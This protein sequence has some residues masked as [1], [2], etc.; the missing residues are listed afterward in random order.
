VTILVILV[1]LTL[2]AVPCVQGAEPYAGQVISVVDFRGKT[3]TLQKP[4]RRIVCL[5]E[6]ALSGFFMLDAHDRVVGIS[7]NVYQGE[8]YPYYAGM[9]RR[10]A[11]KSLPAPGNWDFVNLERVV[12]LD[13]DLVVIWAHQEESIRA[14]EERGI[15][16]FGVFI[17]SFED[18]Y[19]E[20]RAL[21]ELTG[22]PDRA[23]AL[24]RYTQTEILNLQKMVVQVSARPRVYFMWAQGEL[25]SSGQGSTVDELINLAGG[26]NVCGTIDQEHLVVSIERIIEWD[27]EVIVMWTNERRD[28]ADFLALPLWK[29]VTAVQQGNVHEFPGVFPCDLWTLKFQ[30]G[31][32]MVAKWCHPEIF[33]GV[34][35]EK[36]LQ[37]VFS[38]LYGDKYRPPAPPFGDQR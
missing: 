33:K 6:S 9:D 4:A 28:P 8:V 11:E 34:D 1:G 38:Q 5:I 16:V 31:V 32:K 12:A 36:E 37:K 14:M 21:G 10:I 23:D 7:T 19:R 15:Q 17:R 13:P 20:M 27:P 3:V 30:M 24:I 2:A 29:G 25:E 26:M 18:I 22:T 35:M